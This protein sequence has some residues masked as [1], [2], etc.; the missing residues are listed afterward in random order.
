MDIGLEML[1]EVSV[2]TFLGEKAFHIAGQ[3]HSERTRKVWFKKVLTKVV[4]RVHEIETNTKHK[5]QLVYWS[6]RSL[7]VLKGKEYN[8]QEFT[9]CLLR[10]VGVLL[11]FMS[12]NGAILNTP[13]YYQT[14]EQHYT[15]II[16][17]GGDPLQDYYDNKNT[18]SIRRRIVN[19]LKEEGLTD[20]DI[21]MVLNTS[22]YQ[23]K[24]LRK[25]L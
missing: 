9:I 4:K 17:Q 23:I 12:V 19:Q 15:E 8:E 22:E 11:G 10:L 18:I 3:V 13:I 2:R 5:E 21:S 24:K 25:E 16:N 7:G 6:E 1:F 20:F 14:Y